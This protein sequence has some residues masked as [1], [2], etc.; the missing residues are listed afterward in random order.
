M[1][2]AT[3]CCGR[4]IRRCGIRN[5]ELAEQQFQDRRGGPGRLKPRRWLKPTTELPRYSPPFCVSLSFNVLSALRSYFR[6]LLALRNC[7]PFLPEKTFR[8]FFFLSSFLNIF[9]FLICFFFLKFLSFLCL[10]FFLLLPS[11]LHFVFF[12]LFWFHS[13]SLF[14]L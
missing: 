11:Y 9:Y 5:A 4:G 1:D 7:R 14:S 8:S 2:W 3:H 10:F 6:L 13:S 12:S